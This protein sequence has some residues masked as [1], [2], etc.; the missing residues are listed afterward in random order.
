[1]GRTA[2]FHIAGIRHLQYL[3]YSSSSHIE[4]SAQMIFPNCVS[5]CYYLVLKLSESPIIIRS[6]PISLS[7]QKRIPYK[8]CRDG[9]AVLCS[10][11]QQL[12]HSVPNDM[13]CTSGSAHFMWRSIFS[14][15][16]FET[17]SKTHFSCSVTTFVG[18][19]EV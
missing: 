19:K 1:M 15:S 16:T 12:P 14:R 11:T 10:R 17:I 5:N 2:N 4:S 18:S 6:E 3:Q 7:K 13:A 8:W 9:S